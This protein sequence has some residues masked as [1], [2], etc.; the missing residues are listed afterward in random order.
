MEIL[1]FVKSRRTESTY[2]W[3][4][5]GNVLT[6]PHSRLPNSELLLLYLN[7]IVLVLNISSIMLFYFLP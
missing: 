2:A 1:Y 4:N 7:V 6:V 3:P 5:I